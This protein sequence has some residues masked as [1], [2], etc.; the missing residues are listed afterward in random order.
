MSAL[1]V[2]YEGQKGPYGKND[3]E[4]YE[5]VFKNYYFPLYL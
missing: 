5:N 1:L 2:Q 3:D 4:S